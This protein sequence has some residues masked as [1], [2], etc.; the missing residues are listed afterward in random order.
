MRK[1]TNNYRHVKIKSTTSQDTIGS[2]GRKNPFRDKSLWFINPSSS[3]CISSKTRANA[4]GIKEDRTGIRERTTEREG[5]RSSVLKSSQEKGD[6]ERQRAE[7]PVSSQRR[8]T[9]MQGE[10][11]N[12]PGEK[13]NYKGVKSSYNNFLK[14]VK[15]NQMK[16]K[17]EGI[18]KTHNLRLLEISK[19]T[20]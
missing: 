7:I 5:M 20:E 2:S 6:S 14:K 12:L 19:G 9:I 16:L 11:D 18:H 10:T 15:E 8:F 3:V 4:E 1:I 17:L 13:S